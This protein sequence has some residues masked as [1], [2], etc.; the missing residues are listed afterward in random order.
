MTIPD[1][2]SPIVAHRV[3]RWDERGLRSL[4]GELWFPGQHLEARC[5][6]A[7]AARHMTDAINEVPNRKCT[8]GAAKNSEHLRQI[9]YADGGACGEVYLWGRVVEH[10]LG[11]RAQFA[12]PKSLF[13]SARSIPSTLAEMDSR[14]KALIAFGVDIFI[15]GDRESIRLWKNSAGYEAAGLDYVIHTGK[16]YYLRGQW[17]RTLKKGDRVAVLGCGIAVVKQTDEREALV[18]L[19]SGVSLRIARKNIVLNKQNM[20]WECEAKSELVA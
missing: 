14:L 3:W 4:N 2:I 8:C 19:G 5:R 16:E 7:P 17:E 20:R 12:Y 18:V 1:Y 10:S 6:V 13:L 15:A 9:G 11:W